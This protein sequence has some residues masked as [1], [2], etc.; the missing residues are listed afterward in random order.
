MFLAANH[1]YR[2]H[3]S[4][5]R[6]PRFLSV[7]ATF[8]VV[9]ILW[10]LFRLDNPVTVMNVW[11]GMMGFNGWNSALALIWD[12]AFVSIVTIFTWT[13]PNCSQ[14]WPGRSGLGESIFL[15]GLA[16]ISIINSPQVHQFIHFGF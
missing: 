10:V 5:I 7:L 13:V 9:H 2:N 14:R 8:S 12:I 15:Q 6:I 16:V 4:N 11:S 1:L 3:L